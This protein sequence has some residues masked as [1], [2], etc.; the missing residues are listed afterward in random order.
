V[1]AAT[2][3]KVVY[4]HRELPPLNAE[5]AGEYVVEATSVRVPGTLARRSELWTRCHR[6]LIARAEYRVEVEVA[7]LGGRYAHVL[8]ERI[9]PR[10]DDAQGEVWLAGTFTYTLYR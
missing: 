9:D 4:W 5:V 6:D 1:I 3:P 2:E 10:R 8:G 7:R